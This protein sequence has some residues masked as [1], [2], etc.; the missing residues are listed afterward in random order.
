MIA[1][2][3]AS[4]RWLV[5]TWPG[6]LLLAAMIGAAIAW[7]LRPGP[8]VPIATTATS[9]SRSTSTAGAEKRTAVSTAQADLETIGGE[10]T[11]EFNDA[12]YPVRVRHTGGT[13]RMALKT[14]SSVVSDVTFT[15][16]AT[17][18]ESAVT[19]TPLTHQTSAGRWGIGAAVLVPI[20]DRSWGLGLEI[21]RGMGELDVPLLGD[22]P[23]AVFAGV[24]VPIASYVPDAARIGVRAGP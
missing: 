19:S 4:A 8:V 6:R 23:I 11:V 10:T 24:D 14:S 22:V 13:L 9:A 3:R 2:A 1:V 17:S 5:T 20:H 21:S 7:R 15:Q 18:T 12:G 16:T